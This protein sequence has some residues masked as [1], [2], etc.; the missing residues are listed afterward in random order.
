MEHPASGD[1]LGLRVETEP[2][3]MA[4]RWYSVKLQNEQEPE[5]VRAAS[6]EIADDYLILLKEDG[7]IAALFLREVVEH[8]CVLSERN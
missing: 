5:T 7:T 3:A 2:R 1:L 4:E 6:A 8:W